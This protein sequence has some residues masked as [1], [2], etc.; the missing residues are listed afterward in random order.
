MATATLEVIP[1]EDGLLVALK[2]EQWTA[3]VRGYSERILSAA[4]GIVA[5]ECPWLPKDLSDFAQDVLAGRPHTIRISEW[6]SEIG[7]V[8]NGHSHVRS[9]SERGR[10]AGSAQGRA[11]DSLREGVFGAN[12]QRRA[13]D[14]RGGVPLAAKGPVGFRAGR[15]GRETAHDQDIGVALRDRRCPKWPQPR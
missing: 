2:D 13:G 6:L 11:M 8:L 14:R 7:D 9:D 1:S 4:R 10:F 12:S 15:A 5:A 3:Y